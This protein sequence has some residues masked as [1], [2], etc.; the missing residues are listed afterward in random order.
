MHLSLQAEKQRL[1]AV[2]AIQWLETAADENFDRICRLASAYFNVPTVLVS[3]VEKDRQWFAGR[4]GFQ[5]SQTPINQSFCAH[6]IK[7]DGVMQ[8]VDACV[9]PRFMDNELVT[10]EGGI[11]FYA[12]A[13][14]VTRDGHAIGSLC[15]I[16]KFPHQL[17]HAETLVLQDLA[18]MVISQI[19]HRQQTSMCNAV[20]GLPNL[21]QFLTDNAGPW[22][23]TEASTRLLMVVEVV[24]SQWTHD[25]ALDH[26]PGLVGAK[27]A[28]ITTR[29]NEALGEELTAYHISERHLCLLLPAEPQ[30]QSDLILTL[31]TLV[32]E[33]CAEDSISTL[34]GIRMGIA[35]C[36]DGKQSIGDL[37]RKARSAAETAARDGIDWS[38]WDENPNCAS[39]RSES[40]I[41]DVA[42]A[43]SNGGISLVFQP[44]FRLEDGHQVSAEALLRWNHEVFGPVSPAEFIP[45]IERSGQISLVTRWVI[46]NALAHAAA[47]VDS[48]A[49]VSLNL[50]AL[51]FQHI[52]IAQALK[53]GCE[54]HGI[55]AHRVEVEITEG[56]WIRASTT[57]LSQLAEIR[58]LG[59]DV[60]ID[61]FGTGYSNFAY[62][63]EIPANVI[64]LDKSIITDLENKPRNRVIAQSIFQ[65]A[66]QLGYRTVAEGIETFK[67]M[68]LVRGY[69]CHEAQGFFLSR[70]LSGEQIRLTA[71]GSNFLLSA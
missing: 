68:D 35:V 49:K 48:E 6:T 61:D 4:V 2:R 15:L 8:V 58:A 21:R 34:P 63:H 60:A 42:G 3:L 22:L 11:R 26:G 56:E 44:R 71:T 1:A 20:S 9:D 55:G 43:L 23:N 39:R 32:C 57:V 46:D 52:D 53:A 70:P 25:F 36:T 40:L 45:L 29:I 28:S 12:G 18:E 30:D 64:K 24:D 65:L 37:L 47:W 14:L 67:C 19:E 33:P 66:H 54:K 10:V 62:L 50:S 27:A 69:G 51:D 5:N 38:V 41:N 31:S 7:Q 13:P 17:S 16:D 59:V